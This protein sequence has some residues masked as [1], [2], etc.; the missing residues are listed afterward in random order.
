[1]FGLHHK[2]RNPA[3]LAAA[4]ALGAASI[5]I[6]LTEILAP[7]Q[8]ERWMGIGD[9]QNTGILRVLGA[10]E[11]MHGVDI[12]THADDDEAARGVWGRVAGDVLDTALL[13]VAA[14]RTR[15]P[16]SFAAIFGMVLGIGIADAVVAGRL[17]AD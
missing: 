10:R 3:D 13:A 8:L 5:G 15:K 6:G 9:G 16:G 17:S 7:R 12:L 2:T 11:I 4:Q 1:M 14:T